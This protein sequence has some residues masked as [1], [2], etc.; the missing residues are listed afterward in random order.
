MLIKGLIR[1]TNIR[2]HL[3]L[4]LLIYLLNRYPD[5][6]YNIGISMKP[7]INARTFGRER[8]MNNV[9]DNAI[10]KKIADKHDENMVFFPF[11]GDK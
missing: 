4:L 3:N 7:T 10:T 9:I 2:M 6:I 8:S 5:H 1:V 11:F